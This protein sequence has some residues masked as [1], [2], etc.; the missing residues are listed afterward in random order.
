MTIY[1]TRRAILA[2]VLLGGA[3]TSNAALANEAVNAYQM[4]DCR[5]PET[6]ALSSKADTTLS[7]QSSAENQKTV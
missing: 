7:S 4:A 2:F 5:I 1:K 3:L 6:A